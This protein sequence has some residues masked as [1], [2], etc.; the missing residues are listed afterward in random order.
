MADA[1]EAQRFSVVLSRAIL[2]SHPQ[3]SLLFPCPQTFSATHTLQNPRS[4]FSSHVF[5]KEEPNS[6]LAETGCYYYL[7]EKQKIL[8]LSK[9]Q[10]KQQIGRREVE[11]TPQRFHSVEPLQTPKVRVLCP[12]FAGR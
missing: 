5:L 7:Q 2:H 11:T 8:I 6:V 9:V 4:F 10:H 12:H 3:C 1:A